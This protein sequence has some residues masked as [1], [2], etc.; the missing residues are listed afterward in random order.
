MKRLT[1]QS[2]CDCRAPVRTLKLT[3][4][5]GCLLSYFATAV[6]VNSAVLVKSQI[7]LLQ[8]VKRRGEGCEKGGGG[9]GGG[10]AAEGGRG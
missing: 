5:V 7:I 1:L 9:G 3:C 6:L 8:E 2:R 4:I 10:G